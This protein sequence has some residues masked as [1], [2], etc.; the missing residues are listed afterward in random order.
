VRAEGKLH[1]TPG[2]TMKGR[3]RIGRITT[4]GVITE[5]VVP[6]AHDTKEI[7]LRSDGNRWLTDPEGQKIRRLEGSA[8]ECHGHGRRRA[9]CPE[10]GGIM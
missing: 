6:G 7:A 4:N 1:A 8:A 3:N 9:N 5:F 10:I 2:V